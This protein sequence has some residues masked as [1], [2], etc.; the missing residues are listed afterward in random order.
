LKRIETAF[1]VEDP[2]LIARLRE[3]LDAY[4]ADNCQSWVL[5]PDGSYL[6][7]H[8]QEGEEHIASQLML[9]EQLTGNPG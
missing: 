2:A 8:P 3:D 6:Q 5:Q 4:L 1:P 9:L 7:N